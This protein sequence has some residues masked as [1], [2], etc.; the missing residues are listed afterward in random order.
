VLECGG[1]PGAMVAKNLPVVKGLRRG[2]VMVLSVL[3]TLHA[4]ARRST[5]GVS[6]T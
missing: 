6:V 1:T 3:D 5:Q 4:V 2:I